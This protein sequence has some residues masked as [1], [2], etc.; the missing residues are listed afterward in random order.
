MPTKAPNL[1]TPPSQYDAAYQRRLLNILAQYFNTLDNDN[2]KQAAFINFSYYNTSK[3]LTRG[4]VPTDALNGAVLAA[5]TSITVN[6]TDNF[7][8]SGDAY[9]LDGNISDKIQ[10]TGKTATTLTGVT[11]IANGHGSGKLVVASAKTGDVFADHLNEYT[12][13][14]IP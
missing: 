14:I 9:I 12:L 3:V 7:E 6:S 5:A 4:L 10:Y 11:G 8:S 1:P 13:K 2:V